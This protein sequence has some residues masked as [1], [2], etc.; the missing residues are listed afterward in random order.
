MAE[1]AALVNGNWDYFVALEGD[2]LRRY[3]ATPTTD[4]SE[5]TR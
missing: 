5:K 2:L 1:L 3:A 4:A